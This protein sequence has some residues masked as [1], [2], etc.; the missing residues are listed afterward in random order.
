MSAREVREKGYKKQG[1]RHEHRI[2]AETYLGRKLVHGE[3]VHHVDGNSR[4]NNPGNL[5]VFPNQSIHTKCHIGKVGLDEL[6]R[7]LISKSN[8]QY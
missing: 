3:I 4:N 8:F 7:F 2:V 5:A 6:S 1:G